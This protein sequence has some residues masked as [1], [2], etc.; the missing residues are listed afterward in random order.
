VDLSKLKTSDRLKVGGALGFLIFGFFTWVEVEAFGVVG[1][2]GNV[3]DFFWTGVLPWIL[4]I[5]AG[6]VTL[7]LATDTLKRSNIPWPLITFAATALGALL[8]LLRLLFNPLEGKDTIED[9]G[10]DVS[11]GFGLY[12][13]T[14]SAIVAAVGGFLGFK[15]SGGDL[16]DLKD[17][18]KLKSSFGGSGSSSSS[19]SSTPPP[20]PPFQG[21]GAPPPP[22]PPPG[23]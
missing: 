5:G 19:G 22:P 18:N 1:D 3:F 20:P 4:I 16:N 8:V 12:L 7:L 9:V 21:G 6:V 17:M 13:S 23:V 10:G 2:S 14:I 11:R 15:E